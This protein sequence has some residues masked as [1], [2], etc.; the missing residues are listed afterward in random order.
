MK[1]VRDIYKIG[2]GPSSSHTMGPAFAAEEFAKRCGDADL[3]KVILYGSLAKTGKG[4]GTDRAVTETLENFDTEVVFNM[5]DVELPHPNT[6]DFISYKDGKENCRMRALS[7]GGGDIKIVGD[8]AE[9]AA[10]ARSFI[11]KILWRRSIKS[12]SQGT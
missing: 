8:E 4:H 12:V 2:V 9:N 6:V 1:S 11:K 3:I 7:I 5:E 10:E